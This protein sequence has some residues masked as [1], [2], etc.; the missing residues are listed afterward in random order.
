MTRTILSKLALAVALCAATAPVPAFADDPPSA[1]D[2]EA[3]K[4]AFGEGKKAHEA[5]KLQDAIEKFQKSYNLSKNPLL[6][7]NI[8][9][10]M[11]EAGMEDIAVGYYKKFL[12]DAPA[13]AAQRS[14]AEDNL[15]NLE[16]KLG[17]G[18][19]TPPGPGGTKPV[20][21]TT[22]KGPIVMKPAGTYAETDFQHA[23]VDV[24]PPGKPLDVTAYVPEDSGWV[25]T[26]NFRTAGEGK[27]TPREMKWRYKELV[28]RVP[29][30]KMI[31]DA[32]QYYIEVKDSAG[33]VVTRSGKAT[34]PN[35]VT[36]ESGATPRFYPDVTDAGD[37]K[38]TPAEV[39]ARDE[40][41]DPL[42]GTKS[43]TIEDETAGPIE[44]QPNV[45]PGGGFRDVGSS[46]F[47]Y[48]K[49][50]STIATGALL[51]A[52]LV[53]Y[54]QAGR[55]ASALEADSTGCGD[56]PCQEFDE[57]SAGYEDSGKLND[58]L[59]KVTLGIGAVTAV[60]AGYYWYKSLTA[61]QRGD[62]NA[63]TARGAALESASTSWGVAPAFGAGYAGATAVVEF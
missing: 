6:L 43:T 41:D 45:A 53:F 55:N 46:K 7:Y 38:T 2:M 22:P 19:S 37:T 20:P 16:K 3:A 36:I 31:G 48:T 57:V 54:I 13:D 59:S 60:V 17:G 28:G 29:A 4:K 63:A 5:G 21:D 39:K 12:R 30:P 14:A 56:P 62:R 50:G 47:K 35:L 61:K 34:S 26:L 44:V 18:E 25:V 24:A 1:K 23:V 27:F 52:S 15:K 9:L 33:T 32:V 51:S 11:E 58:T 42:N 8:A 49:W 10:T 40:S